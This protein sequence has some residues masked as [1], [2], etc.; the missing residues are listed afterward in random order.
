M[1]LTGSR[2]T[3]RARARPGGVSV[4]WDLLLLG[5][6]A[7]SLVLPTR[8]LIP[9][10]LTVALLVCAWTWAS[11]AD[12]PARQSLSAITLLGL[13]ASIPVNVLGL[14]AIDVL[15]YALAV[16][17][18]SVSMT[19]IREAPLP[20]G[21]F[22]L[23]GLCTVW[24]CA[25]VIHTDFTQ[26]FVRTATV[27][28]PLAGAF[29]AAGQMHMSVRTRA[30]NFFIALAAFHAVVAIVEVVL[31]SSAPWKVGT[32]RR[33]LDMTSPLIPAVE[34]AATSF[35]HPLILSLVLLL[36]MGFLAGR[37][38]WL[39]VIPR[40]ALGLLLFTGVV[41]SGSRSAAAMG[42]VL[43]LLLVVAGRSTPRTLL[44]ASAVLMATP[45]VVDSGY[46]R[47]I[48][49]RLTSS[50]SVSHRLQSWD[51]FGKLLTE[52]PMDRIFF[53]NGLASTADLFKANLLQASA[54]TV[55]DN[56]LVTTFAHGGA[57]AL[58]LAVGLVLGAVIRADF[59]DLPA[60][61]IVAS[62]FLIF[63]LFTWPA[64]T[65]LTALALSWG[66]NPRTDV[67]GTDRWSRRM[68]PEAVEHARQAE[69]R[70]TR[71]ES[72]KRQ[73]WEGT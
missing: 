51:A 49:Y 10:W 44:A 8:L 40:L 21:T 7:A 13:V 11:Q 17:A 66:L 23:L 67:G 33:G 58:I 53:G 16:G 2:T 35:G 38:G 72:H 29:I 55:V 57:L 25:T 45:F 42:V 54:F 5:V 43:L 18:L 20:V 30:V 14:E 3:R 32:N 24:F 59:R 46:L 63:D 22:A 15:Y 73:W 28:L 56:Q 26:L 71:H 9:L 12:A 36:A 4:R 60:V 62:Q 69:D 50:G 34:R 6:S 65:V 64:T 41:L 37:F 31:D 68:T 39:P 19:R 52:Q 48:I 70:M 47:E 61:V 1:T 27:L